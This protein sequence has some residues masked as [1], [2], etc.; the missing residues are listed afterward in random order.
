MKNVYPRERQAPCYPAAWHG[1]RP[2]GRE[3]PLLYRG[4]PAAPAGDGRDTLLALPGFGV[5]A[6]AFEDARGRRGDSRHIRV[7]D[8]SR[9]APRRVGLQRQPRSGRVRARMPR[10]RHAAGAAHRAVCPRR[11]PQRRSAG[12]DSERL[13]HDAAHQRPALYRA[14]PA[15]LSEDRRAGARADVRRRRAGDRHTA[16]E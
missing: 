4:R 6:R 15:V 9:G 2:S 3:Q 16:G 11:V 12:L 1:R 14:R 7:L 13:G 5:A 10:H 8:T